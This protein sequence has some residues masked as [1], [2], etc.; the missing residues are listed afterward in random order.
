MPVS[1]PSALPEQ[2]LPIAREGISA[3]QLDEEAWRDRP[4]GGFNYWALAFSV[5]VLLSILA[6]GYEGLS[7]K[8]NAPKATDN[9]APGP[10]IGKQTVAE[11][12]LNEK[13]GAVVGTENTI[14]VDTWGCSTFELIQVRAGSMDVS[15][16]G[17]IDLNTGTKVIGPL[18]TKTSRYGN[19]FSR[20]EVPG[21]GELWTFF[22][23]LAK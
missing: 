8:E 7:R 17:C 15:V 9:T 5:V 3:P 6:A 19:K 18:E 13:A 4:K 2:I 20:I 22:N 21:H 14:S 12:Q 10:S 1:P 23:H 11:K 16:R